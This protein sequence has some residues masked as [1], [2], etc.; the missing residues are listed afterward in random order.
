M[1]KKKINTSS[2]G[3]SEASNRQHFMK[4]QMEQQSQKRKSAFIILGTILLSAAILGGAAVIS[5]YNKTNQFQMKLD[6][7]NAEI[8]QLTAKAKATSGYERNT[9]LLNAI[10]W[11]K[12][13]LYNYSKT[14][15][16]QS[17]WHNTIE[18]YADLIG[19]DTQN[20]PTPNQKFICA[21]AHANMM[22][23]PPGKF[24]MGARS[25][26]RAQSYEYPR[27]QVNITQ[28]FWMT[29]DEISF[30]QWW[31]C[32][33]N[34]AFKVPT[35]SGQ[36]ITHYTAPVCSI[37]WNQAMQFCQL[38][39]QSEAMKGNLPPGYE[40]RL[41]T[42][43]EWEYACRGGT[44][45]YY[46]WGDEFSPLGSTYANVWDR[47]ALRITS[48]V[49]VD[50]R[51]MDYPASDSYVAW[52]PVNVGPVNGFG[53]R[54]MIGNID[55]WCMDWFNPNYRELMNQDNPVQMVPITV[56][57]NRNA[58]YTAQ[59]QTADVVKVIRGGNW[60]KLPGKCRCASRDFVSPSMANIGIGFR[61]VLAPK[62]QL[63]TGVGG[64]IVEPDSP[65]IMEKDS[66]I[67]LPAAN[68]LRTQPEVN[69]LF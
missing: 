58:M 29:Q 60:G 10:E 1:N 61:M 47:R 45:T 5:S 67:K 32:G 26:E 28:G 62:I 68:E 31:L 17:Y 3:V 19:A 54:N 25:R 24:S 4:M 11:M 50:S 69:I 41:P 36:L 2:K 27:H 16:D 65:I 14:T 8:T 64:R 30:G 15:A 39:T 66:S 57:W 13:G 20:I 37:T 44:E 43:A 38:I 12:L 33:K 49:V 23:I 35:W 51:N 9:N 34:G 53:L 48:N 63:K 59:T 18:H 40:Y 42:E 21:S 6:A 55:E 46:P 56:D 22:W 7:L 52:R